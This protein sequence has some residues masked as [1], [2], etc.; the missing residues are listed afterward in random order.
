ME[1]GE[2]GILEVMEVPLCQGIPM[3][4]DP[5]DNQL[6]AFSSITSIYCS[7]MTLNF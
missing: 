1:V 4:G 6:L 3:L 7:R 2:T 5:P